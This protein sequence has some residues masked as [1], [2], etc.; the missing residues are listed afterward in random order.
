[1]KIISF[2]VYV[3]FINILLVSSSFGQSDSKSL[4]EINCLK[5]LTKGNFSRTENGNNY[6]LVD[7][8]GLYIYTHQEMNSPYGPTNKLF[9][10]TRKLVKYV[11]FSEKNLV[12]YIN[13]VM[14]GLR[15]N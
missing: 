10:F 14:I 3:I 6:T 4:K 1:M 13:C 8:T 15:K 12:K 9:L 5:E 11:Y 7:S 2:I